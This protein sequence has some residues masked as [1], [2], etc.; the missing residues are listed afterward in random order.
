MTIKYKMDG[1]MQFQSIEY[2]MDSHTWNITMTGS[3][4][5]WM[6]KSAKPSLRCPECKTTRVVPN[7]TNYKF[8]KQ[9]RCLNEE[10]QVKSF[11]ED[12]AAR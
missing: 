11:N 2:S 3:G 5:P 9:Y 4:W 1:A 12:H 10:C 8:K 7:G 6:M